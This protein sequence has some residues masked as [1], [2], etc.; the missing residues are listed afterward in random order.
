MN[1]LQENFD[2]LT[3]KVCIDFNII[4]FYI[5]NLFVFL[6]CKNEHE[7]KISNLEKELSVTIE[8]T[9][10]KSQVFKKNHNEI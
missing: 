3:T 9:N 8:K 2:S 1:T 5:F 10:L 7:Q 6:Q 4:I